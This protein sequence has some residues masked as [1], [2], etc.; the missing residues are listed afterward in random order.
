LSNKLTCDVAAPFQAIDEVVRID[1]F[2]I[3]TKKLVSPGEPAFLGHFPTYPIFPG[4]FIVEAVNQAAICYGSEYVGRL[5][6]TEIRSVRFFSQVL[7][8]DVLECDC[9]CVGSSETEVLMVDAVCCCEARKVASVKLT[10]RVE[11]ALDSQPC[12]D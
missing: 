3:T 2:G 6:M 12:R 11:K 9:H 10:Y 8:G 4:V 5:R 7:P 1:S